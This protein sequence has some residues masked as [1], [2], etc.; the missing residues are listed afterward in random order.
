[1]QIARTH[2]HTHTLNRKLNKTRCRFKIPS[3]LLKLLCCC[4]CHTHMHTLTRTHTHTRIHTHTHT[5]AH[6]RT[7]THTHTHTHTP[8]NWN[9]C[10]KKVEGS[11]LPAVVDFKTGKLVLSLIQQ[12]SRFR[13]RYSLPFVASF[14]KNEAQIF[15]AKC[16]I[17]P[18]NLFISDRKQTILNCWRLK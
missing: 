7:H 11:S 18:H 13:T 10:Q 6:T 12:T 14:R 2:T 5:C 1:M 15:F 9:N 4:R 16:S 3:Y 17:K 8:V